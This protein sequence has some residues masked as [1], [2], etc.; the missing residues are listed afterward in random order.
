M[1]NFQCHLR[2][3]VCAAEM[4]YS[5]QLPHK[6]HKNSKNVPNQGHCFGEIALDSQDH[7]HGKKKSRAFGRVWHKPERILEARAFF[8]FQETKESKTT[9]RLCSSLTIRIS[10]VE[11]SIDRNCNMLPIK[12]D[13]LIVMFVNIN[14]TITIIDFF[15]N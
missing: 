4:F 10:M 6:Y 3:S 11:S 2:N 8:A 9:G 5:W 7:C 12:Y 13:L 14:I 1:P 15:L